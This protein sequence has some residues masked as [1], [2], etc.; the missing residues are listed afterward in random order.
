CRL[1]R[2]RWVPVAMLLNGKNLKSGGAGGPA[3]RAQ[4]YN[5]LFSLDF[6]G[7][8]G[9][10][11]TT[12]P[13][14]SKLWMVCPP[15]ACPQLVRLLSTDTTTSSVAKV[16]G[17]GAAA[18]ARAGDGRGE[19]VGGVARGRARE[20]PQRRQASPQAGGA[21]EQ[22]L[23]MRPSPTISTRLRAESRARMSVGVPTTC[24]MPARVPAS[25]TPGPALT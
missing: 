3:Q 17:R 23:R 4:L 6:S 11:Q 18:S 12:W 10:G 19:R 16:S 8:I 9:C 21:A 5:L 20:D 24:N 1:K 15:R 22:C 25:I 2:M 14:G 13:E 7:V